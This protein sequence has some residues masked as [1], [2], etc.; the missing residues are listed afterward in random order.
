MEYRTIL[1]WEF[2][3]WFD[4]VAG[5]FNQYRNLDASRQYFMNHWY[6]DPWKDRHAVFVAMDGDVIASTLRVFHRKIYLAGSQYTMGGIGEVST[7]EAYRRRG[8]S[9]NLL[10]MAIDYMEKERLALSTL[11]T[12]TPRHYARYGWEQVPTYLQQ[13]TVTPKA[14]PKAKL[15][16]LE[17]S[18]ELRRIKELYHN[19]A[20]QFN[21]AVVRDSDA[22]WRDWVKTEL[23]QAWMPAQIGRGWVLKTDGEITAYLIVARPLFDNHLRVQDFAC[24]GDVANSFREL[25]QHA[26]WSLGIEEPTQV[27]FPAVIASDL[28]VEWDVRHGLMIRVN[29]QGLL[30]TLKADSISDL[31]HGGQDAAYEASR[32]VEWGI[33]GF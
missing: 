18:Y 9:G 13:A 15:M 6:N 31:F 25:I 8:L 32:L 11:G 1:P 4:H 21:G 33:D 27:V 17:D 14:C 23:H 30:G 3:A 26:A 7:K 20:S 19:Y 24:Q 28:P 12:G 29:D 22:Y 10:E 5:V 16:D 2:D